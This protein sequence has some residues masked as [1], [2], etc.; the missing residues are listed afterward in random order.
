MGYK[1]TQTPERY[2]SRDEFQVFDD[3]GSFTDGDL[4]TK[5]DADATSTVAHQ[6][7]GRGYVSVLTSADNEEA[8]LATTNELFKFVA[9]KAIVGEARVSHTIPNTDDLSTFFGFA[10]AMGA[11]LITDDGAAVAVNDSGAGIYTT[12]DSLLYKFVT[13]IGGTAVESTSDTSLQA[14]EVTLKIEITPRSSTVFVARPFV[15][16]VQLKTSDGVPIAHDITLGTSTD[17]DFG[18]YVKGHNAADAAILT[19]YLF[20]SQVR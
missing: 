18:V 8:C 2:Y 20:A 9:D 19:D 16:G 12:K 4:W 1:L 3:F 17:M 11:D 13:S 5:L 10:D 7:A 6:G 15:D 14:D